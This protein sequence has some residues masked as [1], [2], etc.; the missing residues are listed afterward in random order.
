MYIL[1]LFELKIDAIKKKM[2]I[3]KMAFNNNV[4]LYPK[5]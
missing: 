4:A 5:L 3:I 1:P 2:L